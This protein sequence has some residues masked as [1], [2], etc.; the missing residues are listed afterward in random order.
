MM[1]EAEEQVHKATGTTVDLAVIPVGVGSFAQ[2]AVSYWKSRS[3]PCSTLTVEPDT[4]AC[5][6]TSLFNGESTTVETD[7]TIMSG[8]NCGTVSTIAWP[9]LKQGVDASVAIDDAEADRA[10]KKLHNLGVNAGP[11]GAATYAAIELAAKANRD[12]ADAV[13]SFNS[14]SII[15]LFCTEGTR[16]Y[17]LLETTIKI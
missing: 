8:L 2:A 13:G 10:V 12:A 1:V 7:D 4:A 9:I 3:Y 6:Q 11:C 14:E 15:V 16:A 5:L 17:N